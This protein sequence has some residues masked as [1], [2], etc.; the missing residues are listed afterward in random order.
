MITWSQ[1]KWA[2]ATAVVLLA[3]GSATML[4]QKKTAPEPAASRPADERST[5]L[6]ALRFL[7]RALEEFDAPNV[8][9][10]IFAQNPIQERFRSAMV[11]LVRTE[12][13]M[14]Q[15]LLNTFG[16]NATPRLPK[17]PLFAI[18][19]GQGSLDAAEVDI[20]G[21]NATVRAPNQDD[22]RDGTRLVQ[23]GGVWKVGGDKADSPSSKQAMESM[24]RVSA[25][26]ESFTDEVARGQY[27]TLEE[28]L[29]SMRRRIGPMLRPAQ[30]Q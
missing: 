21:T 7:A 20:Q 25:A 18:G 11:N 30:T 9:D 5:P 12:G 27:Q 15:T 22:K 6:G 4:A 23:V 13:E 3:G 1:W 17:R 10:S 29:R 14:R 28:A 8:A 24:E 26:V 19:F 2:L 16:A